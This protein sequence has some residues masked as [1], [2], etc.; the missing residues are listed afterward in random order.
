MRSATAYPISISVVI[1]Q[2][3]EIVHILDSQCIHNF[4]ANTLLPKRT[5]QELIQTKWNRRFKMR[6]ELYVC[7]LISQHEKMNV[8]Q[9]L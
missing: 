7:I 4:C 2:N 8:W 5:R 3:I 9:D 1:Q 6:I